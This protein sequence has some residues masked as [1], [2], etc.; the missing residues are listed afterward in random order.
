MIVAVHYEIN[1]CED[2][3]IIAGEDEEIIAAEIAAF[4][5]VRGLDPA[6]CNAWTRT[7]KE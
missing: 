7:I 4:F 2:S 5:K 1:E 3:V 6:K